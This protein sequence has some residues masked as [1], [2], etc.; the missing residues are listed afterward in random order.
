MAWVGMEGRVW[1]QMMSIRG[2]SLGRVDVMG[3]EGIGGKRVC[4]EFS[5]LEGWKTVE[6]V[7]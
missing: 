2:M 3:V 6:D 1:L 5:R 4:G 7:Q